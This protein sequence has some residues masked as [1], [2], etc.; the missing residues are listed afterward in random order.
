MTAT[1]QQHTAAAIAAISQMQ[2]RVIQDA[3]TEA[4]GDYWRRRAAQFQAARPQPTDRPGR[5]GSGP[6]EGR[7]AELSAVA[8]ACLNRAQLA[9]M[10]W[11][12]ESMLL[13]ALLS[14]P[15]ER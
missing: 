13:D 7:D 9:D 2:R 10:V 3:L 12:E 15:E 5:P 4:T 1:T 8:Q 6:P 11:P 14:T